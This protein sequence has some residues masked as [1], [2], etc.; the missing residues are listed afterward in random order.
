M[1]L[2]IQNYLCP[3]ID[4]CAIG[5]YRCWYQC[6]LV[7]VS[8]CA[9]HP[10]VDFY[11]TYH[12]TL[13]GFSCVFVRDVISYSTW[14][15]PIQ[16]NWQ[17][18][19]LQGPLSLSQPLSHAGIIDIYCFSKLF[20]NVGSHG[21][22]RSKVLLGIQMQFLLLAQHTL[23]WLKHICAYDIS[24]VTKHGDR[25]QI[26]GCQGL[27]VRY[28]WLWQDGRKHVVTIGGTVQNID[29][30]PDNYIDVHIP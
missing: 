23:Y 14:N 15:S 18:S 24:V 22:G 30:G 6:A 26:D 21:D 8:K 28:Y 12:I 10:Q 2:S 16:L 9:C 17:E 29:H 19:K 3:H 25:D 13:H 1:E 5:M 11:I 20:F 4:A 27:K 7:S